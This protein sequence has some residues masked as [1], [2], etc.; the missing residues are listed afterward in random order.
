VRFSSIQSAP[1]I[2]AAGLSL[3][4]FIQAF[5]R[6]TLGPAAL[7]FVLQSAAFAQVAEPVSLLELI[8]RAQ[9]DHP[10]V[11]AQQ[12]LGMAARAGV[13]QAQWQYWPSLNLAV[14]RVDAKK[15]DVAYAG[16]KH[17]VTA[18]IRQPLWTGGRLTAALNKSQA[19]AL[20]SE[21]AIA[22]AKEALALRVIQSYGEAL[23]SQIKQAAYG[24]SLASHALLM[25]QVRRRQEEGLSPHADWVL[26]QSRWQ[27]VAAELAALAL[28]NKNAKEQL[29][30]L[31]GQAVDQLALP[32]TPVLTDLGDDVDALVADALRMSPG[33]AHL[34]A[35]EQAAAFDVELALASR[36]PEVYFRVERQSGNLAS[37]Q[38]GGGT[39][40]FVGMNSSLQAGL[41]GTSAVQAAQA[42][43]DAAK[44]DVQTQ[45][46][47]LEERVRADHASLRAAQQRVAQ[48]AV[49]RTLAAEVSSSW[50]RQFL[51]GRKQW[52]DV[53]NAVREL[54]QADAQLADAKVAT[55][56]ALA[57][58]HVQCKG[59]SAMLGLDTTPPDTDGAQP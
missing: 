23:A 15:G 57:R 16:D 56:T 11:R 37:A 18:S 41:S 53:M 5:K 59:V 32:T 7:V 43:Q 45:M 42:R 4:S 8:K 55:F 19:Q 20:G 6:P 51:G 22:E 54:A 49:S 12:S 39:R 27:A 29:R 21:A 24:Q 31:T 46:R 44:E 1:L 47:Q 9:S 35:N 33:H 3:A 36:L 13:E 40:A 10:S 50:D 17:V 28:Q 25:E 34:M 26:A 30:Q 14:E 52:Q 2:S 48:L 38:S 58:L